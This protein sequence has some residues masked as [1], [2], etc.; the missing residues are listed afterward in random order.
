MNIHPNIEGSQAVTNSTETGPI[1]EV[2]QAQVYYGEKQAIIDVDVNIDEHSV[3]A[4][5]GPS[6]CGKSTLL[7]ADRHIVDDERL[8]FAQ[9]KNLMDDD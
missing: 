1:I 6:G 2:K 7:M 3:T 9:I 4:F 8:M 5:I